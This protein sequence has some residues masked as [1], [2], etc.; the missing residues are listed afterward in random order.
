MAETART[1]RSALQAIGLA[2]AGAA[3]LWRFLTP[4]PGPRGR[5]AERMISLAESEIP[6]DG[7]LVLPQS[8]IA[9]VRV[10]A[11]L[12]ALDLACT[13]LGCT[14]TAT[15][16][17]FACPCHGSRFSSAGAVTA[18][19]APRPLRQLEVTV[20]GGVVRVCRNRRPNETTSRHLHTGV[21]VRGG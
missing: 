12:L 9:V 8:G 10:G 2:L 16:S 15:E 11:A 21:N 19:P 3:G 5:S 6:A 13:H 7:A 18:G 20:E 17:G 1:R 4:R 14:V